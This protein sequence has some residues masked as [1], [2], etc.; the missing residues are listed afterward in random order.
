MT[1]IKPRT[2]AIKF[3]LVKNGLTLAE[4]SKM[5]NY[6]RSYLSLVINGK[7]SLSPKT[8]SVIAKTLGKELEELFDIKQKEVN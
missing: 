7:R 5:I 2:E 8:A 1:V 4:F 3:E 6:N